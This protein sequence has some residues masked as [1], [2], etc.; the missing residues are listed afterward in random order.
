[1]RTANAPRADGRVTPDFLRA[2]GELLY[3]ERWQTPLAASL[4]AI[5]GKPLSPATVH[6]WTTRKR[7]IPPWVRDALSLALEHGQSDMT[8]R[9]EIAGEVARLMRA[10]DLP[11][12]S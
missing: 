6:Q 11:D 4:G 2:V 3:G 7:S 1:M 10:A 5:R 12:C 8:S 9:A